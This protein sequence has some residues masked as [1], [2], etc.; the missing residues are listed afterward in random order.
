MKNNANKL[1]FMRIAR[2]LA[3][4]ITHQQPILQRHILRQWQ[5]DDIT[6]SRRDRHCFAFGVLYMFE[7]KVD[8]TLRSHDLRAVADRELIFHRHFGQMT[9]TL[10]GEFA[11]KLLAFGNRIAVFI[12]LI[13]V[14][15][16]AAQ[17]AFGIA[18]VGQTFQRL[19]QTGVERF[20]GGGVV[21]RFTVRAVRAQ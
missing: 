8:V 13:V 9:M 1:I 20:T 14:V 10:A 4:K 17:E 19:Q 3:V 7:R 5:P 21:D 18:A 15:G 16:V 12:I 11:D 6:V 2:R